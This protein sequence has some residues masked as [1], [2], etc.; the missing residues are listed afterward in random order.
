MS[1]IAYWTEMAPCSCPDDC[2]KE[3]T[4]LMQNGVQLGAVIYFGY[5]FYPVTQV[6]RFGAHPSLDSAKSRV[7][8]FA[9]YEV[10]S[11]PTWGNA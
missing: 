11:Y 4:Y 8:D 7:E 6:T 2:G 10:Y 9:A 5:A 1:N 3:V